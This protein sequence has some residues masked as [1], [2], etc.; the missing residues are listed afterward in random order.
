[1]RSPRVRPGRPLE[2]RWWSATGR[3]ESS[4]L[5]AVRR[6]GSPALLPLSARRRARRAA[7]T[8]RGAARVGACTAGA[9]VRRRTGG[10]PADPAGRSMRRVRGRRARRCRSGPMESRAAGDPRPPVRVAGEAARGSVGAAGRRSARPAAAS[11]RTERAA[12]WRSVRRHPRLRH[13]WPRRSS[14]CGVPVSMRSP[15]RPRPA[16]TTAAPA[17]PPTPCP[18]RPDGSPRSTA[19]SGPP[20]AKGDRAST[21]R[22]HG[23]RRDSPGRR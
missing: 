21:P 16:A 19:G 12:R 9:S 14:G 13:R 2:I 17:R 6:V 8:R 11:P 22:R 10:R 20:G 3:G 18:S 7:V 5:A 15:T 23:S 4:C 1:V